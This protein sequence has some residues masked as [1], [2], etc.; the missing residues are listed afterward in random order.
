MVG[1]SPRDR[2]RTL[3]P[4]NRMVPDN[5][6]VV[7]VETDDVQ[8]QICLVARLLVG[9]SVAREGGEKDPI[10][11]DHGAGRTTPRQGRLPSNVLVRTPTNR[12]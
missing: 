10:T 7:A 6:A 2:L 8:S 12:S 5:L 11:K 4:R 9:H 3:A 1:N